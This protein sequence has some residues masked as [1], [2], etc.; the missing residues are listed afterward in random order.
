MNKNS[1]IKKRLNLF[2]KITAA[3]FSVAIFFICMRYFLVEPLINSIFPSESAFDVGPIEWLE[4]LLLQ[5]SVYWIFLF[6]LFYGFI[7]YDFFD[8]FID[9]CVNIF[10]YLFM[11]PFF[12]FFIDILIIFIFQISETTCKSVYLSFKISQISCFVFSLFYFCYFILREIGKIINSKA[13]PI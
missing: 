12:I 11:M 4:I 6:F 1:V 5:I 2:L 7:K 13:N 8:K 9:F 3:S 10:G